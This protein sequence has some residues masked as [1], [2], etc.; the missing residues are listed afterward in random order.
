MPAHMFTRGHAHERNTVGSSY[1]RTVSMTEALSRIQTWTETDS[2]PRLRVYMETHA[3][4]KQCATSKEVNIYI[5]NRAT[6]AIWLARFAAALSSSPEHMD[7][8]ASEE[9]KE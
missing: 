3:R 2:I 4:S 7:P 8:P 1:G 6:V 5:A 9:R